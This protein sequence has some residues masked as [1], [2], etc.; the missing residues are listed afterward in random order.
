MKI[1]I[2]DDHP[3]VRE[4][5]VAVLGQLAPD[6]SVLQARDAWEGLQIVKAVCDLD[7]ILLDVMMPGMDGLTAIGEFSRLR[8][9]VP[10][11]VLS[12]SENPAAIR[13]A[14]RAGALGYI[15]KST[16]P[17][18]IVAAVRSVLDGNIYVPAS[19]LRRDVGR[20]DERKSAAPEASPLLTPRQL[21]VL[22]LI[23]VGRSN[24]D[25][26]NA[27]DLSDKTVKAHVTTIFKALNVVNRTQAANVARRLGLV[28]NR[29]TPGETV[30][31]EIG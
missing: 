30:A 11:I 1:L 13:E 28:P 24:K 6:A 25:I 14:L 5:L 23:C 27:L 17:K 7:A 3:V 2:I 4:G 10:L 19:A 15:P 16:D 31:S 18:D 8:P 29:S 20:A 12:S 21:E 9:E 22:G 26:A